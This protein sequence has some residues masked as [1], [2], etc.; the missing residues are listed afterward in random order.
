MLEKKV[1]IQSLEQ[2]VELELA[3][4]SYAVAVY[5]DENSNQKLDRA[6]TGIPTEE[7]GF[8]NDARALMSAPDLQD[9][10]FKHEQNTVIRIHLQ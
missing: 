9:Q 6:F 5:H 8:S 10:I 4:G 2:D 1:K 7:Y 3:P